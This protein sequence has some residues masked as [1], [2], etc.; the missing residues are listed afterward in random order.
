MPSIPV[1]NDAEALKGREL[2]RRV[3]KL[4]TESYFQGA[5]ERILELPPRRIVNPL[6]SFLCHPDLFLRWRAVS[7]MG[8]VVSRLAEGDM[9]SAQVIMRR[10][11]WNLNDESGG[12]GWGSPEAMGDIMACSRPLARDYHRLLISTIDPKGNLLEHEA[13]QQGALWGL[14]RLFHA[15]PELGADC[16]GFFLPFLEMP[17]AARRG[18]A[19]WALTPLREEIAREP[20]EALV[21]DTA[22][23]KLYIDLSLT[24]TQVG[25]LAK[26]AL[27]KF[28]AISFI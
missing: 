5:L 23:I 24:E 14:G 16:G 9:P 15:R 18:L 4:L 21:D 7:A 2:K 10:L 8:R 27:R 19:A 1:P 25:D 28:R 13:L 17:D 6:F 22:V 11:L 12:I 3:A 20:L 26:Q